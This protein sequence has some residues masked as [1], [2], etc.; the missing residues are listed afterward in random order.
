[1]VVFGGRCGLVVAQVVAVPVAGVSVERIASLVIA[2][3]CGIE[4]SSRCAS[5][6]TLAAGPTIEVVCARHKVGATILLQL[7]L[8]NLLDRLSE[9]LLAKV[10]DKRNRRS[11]GG[12]E[13]QFM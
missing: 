5:S 7:V 11:H 2:V 6:G 3:E 8:G 4:A 9:H 1:M 12:V 13:H 10:L